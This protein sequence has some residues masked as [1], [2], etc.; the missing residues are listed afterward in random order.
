MQCLLLPNKD[1]TAHST[2]MT[3]RNS[4]GLRV[5]HWSNDIESVG[6]SVKLV[7]ISQ[8][9]VRNIEAVTLPA[10]LNSMSRDDKL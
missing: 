7:T 9:H 1:E 2:C 10:F 8:V 4:A 5:P 6:V 3:G